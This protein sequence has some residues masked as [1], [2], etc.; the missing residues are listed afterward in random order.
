MYMYLCNFPVMLEAV[1]SEQRLW[2]IRE[3]L[4]EGKQL[5]DGL[6]SFKLGRGRNDEMY[7]VGTCTYMLCAVASLPLT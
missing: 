3:I 7:I 6:Y 1:S 4:V 2:S 5:S